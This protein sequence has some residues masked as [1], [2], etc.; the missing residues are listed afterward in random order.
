MQHNTNP[1][2]PLALI[3][4]ETGE[5]VDAL[6]TR[7]G[8][9]VTFDS[10][11]FRAVPS[12]V[13]LAHL[14]KRRNA[15]QAKRNEVIA[16]EAIARARPNRLRERVRAIARAQTERFGDTDLPSIAIVLADDAE[17]RMANSSARL[18]EYLGGD[19]TQHRISPK[20]ADR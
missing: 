19:A 18:D 3:A 11:G 5:D 14:Q 8:S 1:L 12:E 20:R 7:F 13:C 17:D 16:A 10:S 15:I 6:A 2:V 9:A 4:A